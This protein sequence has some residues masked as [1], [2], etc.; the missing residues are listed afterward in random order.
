MYFRQARTFHIVDVILRNLRPLVSIL[1][2]INLRRRAQ[3]YCRL[4]L[5][6]KLLDFLEKT[7]QTDLEEIRTWVSVMLPLYQLSSVYC[8]CFNSHMSVRR[9]AVFKPV[10]YLRNPFEMTMMMIRNLTLDTEECVNHLT[11][12]GLLDT[13]QYWVQAFC[14]VYGDQCC[15]D[16]EKCN[17]L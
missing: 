10:C 3:D 11:I 4:R 12:F 9:S 17:E 6:E 14:C 7:E 8:P 16:C 2:F 13:V 1:W 15:S 5:L